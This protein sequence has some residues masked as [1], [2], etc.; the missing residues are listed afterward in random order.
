MDPS[1]APLFWSLA[2]FQ[3]KH[4]LGD[5]V[6][7]TQHQ[8]RNKGSYGHPAGILHAASHGLLSVPALL[9]LMDSAALLVTV[10][11][12]EAVIHYHVDWLKEQVNVGRSL[13]P[14]DAVY[15]SVFGAD[16]FVHQTT[17]FVILLLFAAA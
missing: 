15:W 7:Q 10:A 9:M 2:L 1:T 12:T 4:F 6:L 17:Y 5:F 8:L 3:L 14:D 11:A 16:Q 13:T